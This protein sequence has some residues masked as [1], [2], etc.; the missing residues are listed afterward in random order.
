MTMTF[1]FAGGGTGGHI[2]PLVAVAQAVREQRSDVQIVFVGT[3]RGLEQNVLGRLGERLELLDIIPIKGAGVKG[4]VRGV[5][6]AA[7]SLPQAR[8][9]VKRLAPCAVLSLGGYAAGPV[10]LAARMSGVAVTILEPNSVLGLANQ[11]MAP[12]AH[13][14]YLTFDQTRKWFRASQVLQTGVPL[15]HGF[16]PRPFT[17]TPGMLRVLVMG[18]SQGARTLNEHV[19]QAIGLVKR[20]SELCLRVVHQCGNNNQDSV[21]RAY[22]QAGMLD[23]VEVLSFID[24]VPEALEQADLVL[25]RA[26]ASAL[27]EV[28]AVGRPS[29]LIPYPFAAANHQLHN[30]RAL[31]EV[32]AA[33][34]IPSEQASPNVLAAQIMTLGSDIDGLTNMA[35][36]ARKHGKP[37]AARTV[38]MDLLELA[39]RRAKEI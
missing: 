27:A 13:R 20:D 30:A 3:A 15:R 19:P 23:N 8:A 6:R 26:G 4:A 1:L 32:G 31:Q 10:S 28:C 38:A 12:V 7:A 24:D 22:E 14:A 33:V 36:A 25:C 5:F 17:P 21:S 37:D 34:C 18:G 9:L 16:S 2:F 35:Y 11:L 39:K 29:V